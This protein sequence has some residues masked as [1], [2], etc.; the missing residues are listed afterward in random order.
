[1]ATLPRP[2]VHALAGPRLS[3]MRVFLRPGEVKDEQN[4]CT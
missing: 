3:N 4:D 1:M 2:F